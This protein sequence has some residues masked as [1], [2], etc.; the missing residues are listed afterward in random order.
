[1][2]LKAFRAAKFDILVATDVAARG[3]DI[4]GVELVIQIEPPKVTSH[5]QPLHHAFSLTFSYNFFPPVL[6]NL[7]YPK[8]F[9]Y[10]SAR[11][12]LCSGSDQERFLAWSGSIETE[13]IRCQLTPAHISNLFNGW[14][15]TAY[16]GFGA[17]PRDVHSQEWAHRPCEQHWCLSDAG[18]PQEGG[19]DPLHCQACRCHLRAHRRPPALRDGPH[20]RC[21]TNIATAFCIQGRMLPIC[22]ACRFETVMT[23]MHVAYSTRSE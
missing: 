18:G 23:G 19:P 4:N 7:C 9:S 16:C 2:T 17:G 6:R 20:R 5:S 21:N 15:L 13:H 14:Q 12:N 22:A 3:L 10:C 1:M 11:L 8:L